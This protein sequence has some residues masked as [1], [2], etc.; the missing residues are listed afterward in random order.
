MCK[1]CR[2]LQVAPLIQI[3]RLSGTMRAACPNP[4]CKNQAILLWKPTDKYKEAAASTFRTLSIKKRKTLES[5]VVDF[6]GVTSF[7]PNSANLAI[8]NVS[9]ARYTGD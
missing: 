9:S 2:G 5:S 4:C 6:S 3:G 7:V 1:L 8:A